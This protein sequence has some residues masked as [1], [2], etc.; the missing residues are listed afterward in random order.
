MRI[1]ALIAG[2]SFTSAVALAAPAVD[3]SPLVQGQ[4]ATLLVTNAA[5]SST[6]TIAV[7]PRD[8]LSTCQGNLAACL[9]NSAA[10]KH[11]QLST[12]AAGTATLHFTAPNQATGICFQAGNTPSNASS[13]SCE[14]V[15]SSPCTDDSHEPNDSITQTTPAV[16][17]TTS[18]YS[19]CP[20]NPD[21]LEY[22]LTPGQTVEFQARFAASEGNLD[23]ALF[24]TNGGLLA[25]SLSSTSPETLSYTAINAQR[26]ALGVQL[27]K[28]MARP[29]GLPINLKPKR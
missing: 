4:P 16:V 21:F 1:V 24:D 2:A 5:P 28:T 12:D 14:T 6:V 18:T 3:V 11:K 25:T 19:L 26:V 29:R 22:N 17:G 15:F 7:S 8:A 10:T 23:L 27:E 13:V 20:S 9:Q